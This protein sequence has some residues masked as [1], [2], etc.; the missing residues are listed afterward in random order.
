MP[1]LATR[2]VNAVTASRCAR[3]RSVS[4]RQISPARRTRSAAWACGENRAALWL[5]ETTALVSRATSSFRSS[6]PLFPQARFRLAPRQ[7]GHAGPCPAASG[8]ALEAVQGG[9]ELGHVGRPS[10]MPAFEYGNHGLYLS[11]RGRCVFL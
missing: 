7:V 4:A 2:T 8:I 6:G 3:V 10:A 1:A 9:E 11:R 5:D